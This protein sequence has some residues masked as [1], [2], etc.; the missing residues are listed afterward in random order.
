MSLLR[1]YWGLFGCV[2]VTPAGRSSRTVSRRSHSAF[3]MPRS[4]EQSGRLPV[5]TPRDAGG[6]RSCWAGLFAELLVVVSLSV[7]RVESGGRTVCWLGVAELGVL[8]VG[9]EGDGVVACDDD[10]DEVGC[11]GV[12]DVW[13][14]G[15][16]AD[17]GGEV[18]G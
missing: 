4:F 12:G 3:S 18:C 14:D 13:L 8:C 17:G 11:E 6:T 7:P 16:G 9:C 5:P 10:D 2:D 15:V 1:I